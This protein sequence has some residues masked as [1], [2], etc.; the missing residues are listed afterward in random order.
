MANYS[1]C[2]LYPKP[3][4]GTNITPNNYATALDNLIRPNTSFAQAVTKSTNNS[5]N[6]QQMSA[7]SNTRRN[8][9]IFS[10]KRTN[11][12]VTP[13]PTNNNIT[14]ENNSPQNIIL[15][16]LQ[17]T[18]QA[19]TLLTQQVSNLNFNNPTPKPK[20]IKHI[21]ATIV[22]LTP[23][24]FN[25]ISIASVYVPPKSDERLF[26]LDFEQLL[27]TNSNCVIFGDL[28]ATHN[29]WNCLVNSTR[30]KQ[31]KTFTDTLNLT[32]AYPSSP[33]R[34]GHG[35]SNTLDI[36][37]INNFNFLFTM[38]SIPELSS[39]HN[40]VFLNFSLTSP[41]HQDNARAVTTCWSD[42][43]NNLKSSVHLSD[44]SGIRNP[45]VLEDKISFLT[46]A[47]CSAHQ[48]ASKPIENKKHSFT[49]NHIHELIYIKNKAKR[50]SSG[51]A[52]SDDQK[53][54][55]LAITLK[56]NFTENERPNGDYP[57]DNTIT[58]TL[59]NFFS[60]PPPLPITPTDPDEVLNYI[61]TLSNNKAPESRSTGAVF[62]D[63]QKAFDRVWLQSFRR[64]TD[65]D[66]LVVKVTDSWRAC[67]EFEPSTAET[68]PC[69]ELKC[70]S[71]DVVFF[72]VTF[73]QFY[74]F[75]GIKIRVDS[76]PESS[77]NKLANSS[78]LR[79]FLRA[80]VSGCLLRTRFEN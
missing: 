61:K 47:I 50:F 46:A 9:A 13:T 75:I 38:D 56:D 49:P 42:F 6:P 80:I 10:Q 44:F 68:S 58:T 73:I 2:P 43:R 3:R 70:P 35:T 69:K 63:I 5:R 39:D 1:R 60:H 59:E 11:Q 53:A 24:N 36:A 32:I 16:T 40:P 22:V 30:G 57:I 77:R 41:I 18:I 34:F 8:P 27:Q 29:E 17:Q 78:G 20:K 26:T 48:Q 7:P 14:N 52:C 51:P 62:L 37:V 76:S 71:V 64:C 12:I 54:N 23:P 67:P 55:L 66:S 65:R 15:Q 72:A 21:E 31:L 33:T 45:N 25:P 74:V 79:P 28:N 4:K 19:L